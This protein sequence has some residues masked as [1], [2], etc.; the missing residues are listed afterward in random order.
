MYKY[1][2]NLCTPTKPKDTPCEDRVGKVKAQLQPTLS[3]YMERF[4]FSEA[5]QEDKETVAEYVT[6]FKFLSQQCGFTDLDTS[7]RDQLILV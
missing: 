5:K 7:L 3:I 6:R 1:I 4:K 2:K